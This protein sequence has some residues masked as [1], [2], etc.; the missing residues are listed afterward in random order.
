M[1]KIFATLSFVWCLPLSPSSAADVS[2]NAINVRTHLHPPY[3]LL[4]DKELTGTGVQAMRCVFTQMGR[5]YQIMLSPPN[6]NRHLMTV[7]KVD[8][9]FLKI[10]NREL[11]K[12]GTA[13]EPLAVERWKFFRLNGPLDKTGGPIPN[14]NDRIGSVLGSNEGSWLREH[15]FEKLAFSSNMKSLIKVLLNKRVDYA[16]ADEAAFLQAAKELEFGLENIRSSFVRYVPLVA[17]FSHNFVEDNPGFL[18]DFNRRID[19]CPTDEKQPTAAEEQ[20]LADL[21]ELYVSFGDLQAVIVQQALEN[22]EGNSQTDNELL[23]RKK[24]QDA[25]WIEVRKNN[26]KTET[27]FM[28]SILGNGLSKELKRIKKR[29]KGIISEVFVFDDQGYILGLSEIT[30]DYWQGDEQ[31]Y[32][33]IFKDNKRINFSRIQFDSSTRKFQISVT[34]PIFNPETGQKIAGI[35]FGFDADTSL[36]DY[37][38]SKPL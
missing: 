29:S 6:R 34:M 8:G 5:K 10:P 9:L 14:V 23:D 25:T 12:M 36:S 15:Q 11:N 1:R 30:S 35:T 26:K 33:R 31:K 13:T 21:A 17:Y 38:A 16:L 2:D 32:N 4:K 27:P 7:G 3:Q 28:A 37:T 22:R 20:R 18:N 24:Q 19:L